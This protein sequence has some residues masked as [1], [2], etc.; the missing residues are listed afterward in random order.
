MRSPVARHRDL[1]EDILIILESYHVTLC[2]E[3]LNEASAVYF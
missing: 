3:S 2:H 1:G